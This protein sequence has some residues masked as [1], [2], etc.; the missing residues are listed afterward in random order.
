MNSISR[1]IGPIPRLALAVRGS[2]RMGPIAVRSAQNLHI[3]AVRKDIDSAAK[4]YI[5]ARAS[6]A[7][8][9]ASG[10]GIAK[11]YVLILQM[12]KYYH[13]SKLKTFTLVPIMII[14]LFSRK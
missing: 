13:Q 2:R 9:A 1:A 3:T 6:A 7:G 5:A 12:Y 4:K 14:V 11:I 8:V 10:A